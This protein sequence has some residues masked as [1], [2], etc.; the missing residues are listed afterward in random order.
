[1]LENGIMGSES[2]P[3]LWVYR[4][5]A[6]GHGLQYQMGQQRGLQVHPLKSYVSHSGRRVRQRSNSGQPRE[7]LMK[8][9]IQ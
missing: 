7:G 8:E 6:S 3:W 5:W 2:T 4:L 1:M 9:G